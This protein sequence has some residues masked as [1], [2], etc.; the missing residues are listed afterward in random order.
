MCK[1]ARTWKSVNINNACVPTT[2]EC[3]VNAGT[4]KAAQD[5]ICT[6][7]AQVSF[8]AIP[9]KDAIVP[10]GYQ[11]RYIL[12][13]AGIVQSIKPE[14]TFTTDE[15]AEFTIHTFVY[16][17]KDFDINAI[18]NGVTL[19]REVFAFT[20]AGGGIF[21]AAFDS[22]GAKTHITRF[23]GEV[24]VA[25]TNENCT[26]KGSI[27]VEIIGSE[28][29]YIYDWSDVSGS[30]NGSNRPNIAVGKYTLTVISSEGCKRTIENI[31][32]KREC[33]ECTA[34]AGT[35]RPQQHLTIMHK[36]RMAI[37]SNTY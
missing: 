35:V 27:T 32:V 21:C 19:G 37:K 8:S 34:S 16:H 30:N 3:T 28:G 25:V 9:N 7:D 5:V 23:K 33:L 10:T 24:K 13:K 11:V 14:P 29:N 26:Q 4:L 2:E 36:C 20:K 18:K 31:E 22:K 6:A 12:T 17:P 1:T 15:K